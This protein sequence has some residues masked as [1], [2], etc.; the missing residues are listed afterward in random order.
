LLIKRPIVLDQ[1]RAGFV[2]MERNWLI[3]FL[4]VWKNVDIAVFEFRNCDRL[5]DF[6][7]DFGN[8]VQPGTL[9][10]GLTII[11]RLWKL[12]LFLSIDVN[13]ASDSEAGMS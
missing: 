1:L 2:S 8:C 11:V 10:I 13:S 5:F 9:E 4:V 12:R 6:G 7:C 3:I